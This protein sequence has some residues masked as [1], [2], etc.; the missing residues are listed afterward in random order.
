MQTRGGRA[1]PGHHAFC[2]TRC[3]RSPILDALP[4][5]ADAQSFALAPATLR[6]TPTSFG[7]FFEK[8]A[9]IVKPINGRIRP[10]NLQASATIDL[11][12]IKARQQIAWGSGDYA[13]VGTTIADRRR[14]AVRGRRS[15]LQA[16][17]C[18]T[19]P[20]VT[21]MRRSPRRGASPT[22]VS[23][24]YVG[25]A[26]RPRALAGRGRLPVRSPSRRPTRKRCPSP[27]GSFDV[28]LSTFGVHVR[29][30]SGAGGARARPRLPP[31]R[32]DRACQLDAGGLHRQ[33]LQDRSANTFR[34]HPAS[35]R[36]RCGARQPTSRLCSARRQVVAAE[37]RRFAFRY[38]S[39]EHWLDIFR[40]YYGPV[41]KAFAAIDPEAREALETDLYAL[42]D[43][44]NVAG[45]RHAGRSQ[46]N[47][48]KWSSP[49]GA[50]PEFGGRGRAPASVLLWISLE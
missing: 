38:K 2:G 47:I 34:R 23:T 30:E 1:C 36:R 4:S 27:D 21:A 15:A 28:V 18:S 19:S 22:V 44:F 25:R 16:S 33:A 7:A 17:A 10:M 5:N 45:G 35:N 31:R 14:D 48:S 39:P 13:I 40:T 20:P 8:V 9:A 12:A 46:P 6:K 43:E 29:A 11:A 41:L 24:D 32:Q 37:R 3:K 26:A 49:K 50:D 42:L